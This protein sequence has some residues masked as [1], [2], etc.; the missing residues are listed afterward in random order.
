MITQEELKSVLKYDQETGRFTWL[1]PRRS[2]SI[3]AGTEAG[4]VTNQGYVHVQIGRMRYLAHRLAWLY[5]YGFFPENSIDHINRKRDDNR[6]ENLREVSNSCNIRNSKS[7]IN[8][9][10][11][12]R[13]VCWDKASQRW[14]ADIKVNGKKIGLGRNECFVEVVAHR[15]AGEQ[16]VEW[17]GCDSTSDAYKYMQAYTANKHPQGVGMSTPRY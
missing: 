4:S 16:A 9:T 8:N 3:K 12:V 17:A 2:G 6:L 7:R 5:T 11:G 15:L 1:V 10:S 13:G 14:Q